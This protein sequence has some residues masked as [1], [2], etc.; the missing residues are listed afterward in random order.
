VDILWDQER[1]WPRRYLRP[2]LRRIRADWKEERVSIDLFDKLTDRQ[3][4]KQ[5]IWTTLTSPQ[6]Y[7]ARYWYYNG[8][9]IGFWHPPTRTFVAW[10]PNKGSSPSR[11]M[12]AFRHPNGVRYMQSFP[13][14]RE[15]RGPE[16]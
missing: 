13:P 15:I 4:S 11:V 12:T 10:K 2:L 8:N 6:T 9:R 3:I 5:D 14:F 16:K 7:I 1:E